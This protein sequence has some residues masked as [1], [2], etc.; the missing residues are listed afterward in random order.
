MT[1][2]N[3]NFFKSVIYA[4]GAQIVSL[5]ASLV[6]SF[7]APKL[8]DV[9]NYAYWQ[10]FL[11]YV[12]YINISRLGLIDGLYL[13]L[14]GK[15]YKDLNYNI[16][17]L[18]WVIFVLF[19][20]IIA[21]LLFLGIYFSG[22]NADRKFI[23][24]ACCICIV[25]INSNNF[26]SYILQTVNQT[27]MYS[28]SVIIQ[29][30]FWFLAIA[31]IKIFKIYTYK[32]I[33]VMYVTGHVFAG[34]YLSRY[35]KEIWN[36]KLYPLLGSL[37]GALKDIRENIKCGIYL[38][39]SLYAGNLIIGISRMIIDKS[40]GVEVFGY[41]SFSLTL[42]NFV[43][44]FINQVSMVMFPEL[45][46]LAADEQVITY[47]LVRNILGIA[48]PAILLAYLPICFIVRWWLPQYEESLKY[49]VFFLPI[50]TFDGKMQMLC[51]TYFKILRKEKLLLKIN[52][53]TMIFS[54]FISFIGSYIVNNIYFVALGL[55]IVIALRS[56]FS[57]IL[58]AKMMNKS[59]L[60][61]LIPE[62]IMVTLYL[63][64]TLIFSKKVAFF[65][66]VICYGIF[67]YF[68]RGILVKIMDE[69]FSKE[70]KKLIG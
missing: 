25:L 55:L 57:E 42:A 64:L 47:E 6:V 65:M 56:I 24:G 28:V 2:N 39:I 66:F 14:G 32:V 36:I 10:L 18:E 35:V 3:S 60:N 34:L 50:C 16:L 44:T 33:V 21:L 45:K 59:I 29:N 69:T 46:R 30:L 1:L 54:A 51:S 70:N 9:T 8:I 37:N 41:F 40:W 20:F 4:I 13:R 68:N 49:L 19:Q 17:S 7:I 58:L 52:V 67:L 23:F 27:K 15:D 43:L 5:S 26:F 48:L 12:T 11:F 61:K 31:V 62:I 22:L 38:M 63:I 53:I